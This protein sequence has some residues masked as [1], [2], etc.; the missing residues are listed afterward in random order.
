MWFPFFRCIHR[1]AG[2]TELSRGREPTVAD[3]PTVPSPVGAAET[4]QD[5][6]RKTPCSS[7]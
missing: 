6:A 3:T 2:A 1:P 7:L 5:D 4:P